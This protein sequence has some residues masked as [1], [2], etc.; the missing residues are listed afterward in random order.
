MAHYGMRKASRSGPKKAAKT[1]RTRAGTPR[2]GAEAER[3]R[4]ARTLLGRTS[5]GINVTKAPKK[6]A[7]PGKVVKGIMQ[8]PKVASKISA[9]KKAARKAAKRTINR[10]SAWKANQ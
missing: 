3:L 6:V 7:K 8:K 9:K 4:R 1:M 10:Y 5:G 2:T